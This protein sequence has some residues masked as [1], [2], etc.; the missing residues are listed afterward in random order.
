MHINRENEKLIMNTHRQMERCKEYFMELT[1]GHK[2]R[3]VSE[4]HG[5][6]I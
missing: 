1:D 2:M 3:R 4:V 5:R 6:G